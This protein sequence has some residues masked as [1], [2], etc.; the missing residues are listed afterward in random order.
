MLRSQLYESSCLTPFHFLISQNA[1][2]IATGK[3]MKKIPGAS[4]RRIVDFDARKN[5]LKLAQ[6]ASLE[7]D[8]TRIF[9][10]QIDR[11]PQRF[12]D[13]FQGRFIRLRKRVAPVLTEV[14]SRP[15]RGAGSHR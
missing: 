10:R 13:L 1:T 6:N 5:P 3:I 12:L 14:P 15:Q 2:A 11:Y 8:Q 4:A 9:R 7:I